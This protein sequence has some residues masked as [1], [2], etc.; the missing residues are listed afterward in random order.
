M[1]SPAGGVRSSVVA[2]DGLPSARKKKQICE[3]LL[4]SKHVNVTMGYLLDPSANNGTGSLLTQKQMSLKNL[5]SVIISHLGVAGSPVAERARQMAPAADLHPRVE[6]RALGRGALARVRTQQRLN[7]VSSPLQAKPQ[8]DTAMYV[9]VR[10]ASTS[11]GTSNGVSRERMHA[12][13]R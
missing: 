13:V 11:R 8:K 1:V 12:C 4:Y 6:R 9:V 5:C 2:K 3:K 7:K 10:S